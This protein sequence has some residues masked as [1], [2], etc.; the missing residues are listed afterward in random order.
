MLRLQVARPGSRVFLRRLDGAPGRG[1]DRERELLQS[2][3]AVADLPGD[4][5]LFRFPQ[6]P[7]LVSEWREV[8]VAPNINRLVRTGLHARVAL[9]A[10]IGLDVVRPA[11]DGVDMHDV[12]GTDVHAVST[13]VAPRHVGVSGHCSQLLTMKLSL[14]GAG[15]SEAPVASSIL[16]WNR[17]AG[18]KNMWANFDQGTETKSSVV[19]KM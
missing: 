10:E 14:D 8:R 19:K 15:R 4:H 13:A 18:L 3:V 11:I 9:P 12:G 16:L 7:D 1:P 6:H 2:P 5:A 17:T